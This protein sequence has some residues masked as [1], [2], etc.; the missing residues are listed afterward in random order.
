MALLP[1]IDANDE[2]KTAAVFKFYTAVLACV[3]AMGEGES[4]E[5][6]AFELPL[7]LDDWVDEVRRRGSAGA[8]RRGGLA[9]AA[10]A[11]VLALAPQLFRHPAPPCTAEAARTARTAGDAQDLCAAGEP[12]QRREPPRRRQRLQGRR[13]G[14]DTGR[15]GAGLGLLPAAR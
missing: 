6:A 7:Y 14:G 5:G 12:G 1:G 2:D 13:D 4:G 8:A 3:P 9:G 15:L 10:H 11:L